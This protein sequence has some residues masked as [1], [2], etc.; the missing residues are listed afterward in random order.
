MGNLKFPD[1]PLWKAYKQSSIVSESPL[2]RTGLPGPYSSSPAH[3]PP[4]LFPLPSSPQD[5]WYAAPAQRRRAR[6]DIG[7]V[8]PERDVDARVV[9]RRRRVGREAGWQVRRPEEGDCRAAGWSA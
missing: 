3:Y 4:L 5:A 1:D 9:H 2:S 6:V 8:G 7:A